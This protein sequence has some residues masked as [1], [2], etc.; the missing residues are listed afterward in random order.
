[1]ACAVRE[2]LVRSRDESGGQTVRLAVLGSL[3]RLLGQSGNILAAVLLAEPAPP[4]LRGLFIAAFVFS[5]PAMVTGL[6]VLCALVILP[7]YLAGDLLMTSAVR[8]PQATARPS[9]SWLLIG[10]LLL[11]LVTTVSF[12]S[13]GDPIRINLQARLLPAGPGHPLGTD[14]DG[15][16]FLDRLAAGTRISLGVAV[17]AACIA[18]VGGLALTVPLLLVAAAGPVTQPSPILLAALVG[19]AGVPVVACPVRRLDGFLRSG[20]AWGMVGGLALVAAQALF[21]EMVMSYMFL[22]LPQPTPSLGVLGYDGVVISRSGGHHLFYLP[23]L[24]M[25]VGVTGLLLLGKAFMETVGS[26][27]GE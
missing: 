16:D 25:S 2:G 12:S 21:V 7:L 17:G 1:M 10:G 26:E 24:V 8:M 22:G 4:G 14:S 27:A 3:G 13:F 18:G 9:R 23:I 5:N 20:G 15:R 11:L 6:L 19:S